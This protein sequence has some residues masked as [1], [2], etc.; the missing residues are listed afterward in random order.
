MARARSVIVIGG[1]ESDV[2]VFP[3]LNR[4]DVGLSAHLDSRIRA[5]ERIQTAR[6]SC[7]PVLEM[8][9]AGTI[10]NSATR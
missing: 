9:V 4:L 5:A 8:D 1:S 2:A 6:G 10:E 3:P 7:L